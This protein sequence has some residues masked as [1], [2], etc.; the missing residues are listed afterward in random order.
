MLLRTADGVKCCPLISR[1]AASFF[2]LFFFYYYFCLE[3]EYHNH[4]PVVMTCFSQYLHNDQ[5]SVSNTKITVVNVVVKTCL[6]VIDLNDLD[7]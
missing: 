2:N 6:N 7:N 4:N 5:N 3:P 1:G